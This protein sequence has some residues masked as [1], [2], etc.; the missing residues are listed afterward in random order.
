[1]MGLLRLDEY[2]TSYFILVLYST[3]LVAVRP[4]LLLITNTSTVQYLSL[5]RST[6]S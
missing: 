5:L 6:V 3:V 2:R 4:Y 1:M